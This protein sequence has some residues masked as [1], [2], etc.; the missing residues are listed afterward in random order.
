MEKNAFSSTG[1]Q[2]ET[3]R[4]HTHHPRRLE[5]MRQCIRV[6]KTPQVGS[7][8]RSNR[9]DIIEQTP[10]QKGMKTRDAHIH[11]GEAI[12]RTGIASTGMAGTTKDHRAFATL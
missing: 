10:Q 11:S 2:Q 12:A 6:S 1:P 3:H 9:L 7:N 4:R 5:H 8:K